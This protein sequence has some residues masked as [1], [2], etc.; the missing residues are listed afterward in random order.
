MERLKSKR[1]RHRGSNDE[2]MEESPTRPVKRKL[3]E[4]VSPFI[5]VAGD[6]PCQEP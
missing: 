4:T 2:N 6:Q 3:F 1:K 5:E